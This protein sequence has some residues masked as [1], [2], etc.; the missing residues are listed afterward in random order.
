M[1]FTIYLGLPAMSKFNV[2]GCKALAEAG[3]P[4]GSYNL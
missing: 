2:V 3:S 1:W 4:I